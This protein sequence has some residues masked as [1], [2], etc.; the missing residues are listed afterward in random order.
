MLTQLRIKPFR[1]PQIVK[2]KH[3]HDKVLVLIISLEDHILYLMLEKLNG[4]V[5][6]L[7][8]K[9]ISIFHLFYHLIETKNIYL[10][11]ALKL[12]VFEIV[13]HMISTSCWFL[14]VPMI[15]SL[16]MVFLLPRIFYLVAVDMLQICTRPY[17]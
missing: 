4:K 14:S 5:Y 11:C 6:Q 16:L 7:A 13:L 15:Y 3:Q 9:N 10:W 12:S 17:L 1:Y 8:K 2:I